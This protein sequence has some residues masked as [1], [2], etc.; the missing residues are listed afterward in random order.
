L[1]PTRES[2]GPES[3]DVPGGQADYG[4]GESPDDFPWIGS[5]DGGGITLGDYITP[6]PD[7]DLVRSE[8]FMWDDGT[9]I[10]NPAGV[11]ADGTGAGN[12]G[13]NLFSPGWQ[14][15]VTNFPL[16]DG[17][18]YT[19]TVAAL[20]S[21]N[22]SNA[23]AL[24]SPDAPVCGFNV[25]EDAPTAPTVTSAAY[26]PSGSASGGEAAGG[27]GTFALTSADPGP[28]CAGCRA[29][30]VYEFTYQLND[31]TLSYPPTPGCTGDSG[32]VLATAGTAGSA[33]ATSCPVSADS[34]GTN[35]MYVWAID[36]AGNVSPSAAY[37]FYVPSS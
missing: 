30:G 10:A 1:I 36:R 25:D 20:S 9:P 27:T 31:E 15:T 17:H 18:Q 8:Y 33:S 26:P 13:E 5:T 12:L 14:S 16:A 23:P 6:A 11:S 4:C 3:T 21:V 19:W 35:I 28:D 37:Y 29:S 32:T 2:T 7:Y 24:L 22:G 34:W